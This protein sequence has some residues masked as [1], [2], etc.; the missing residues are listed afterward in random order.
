MIILWGSKI[1]S[2]IVSIQSI[3]SF[4]F[5]IFISSGYQISYQEKYTDTWIGCNRMMTPF[6]SAQVNENVITSNNKLIKV[7]RKSIF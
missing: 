3:K 1:L 2:R 7:R 6:A 4:L 5:K